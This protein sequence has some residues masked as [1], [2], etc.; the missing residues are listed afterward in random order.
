MY[1]AN[2]YC[3]LTTRHDVLESYM[4]WLNPPARRSYPVRG[5]FV[6]AL[7]EKRGWTQEEFA[8]IVGYSTRLIRKA[9]ASEGLNPETIGDIADALGTPSAP[10]YPE[11][12]V[13]DPLAA[14]KLFIESYDRYERSMLDHCGHLFAEDAVFWCAGE[15]SGIPFAGTYIGV[16]GFQAFLDRFFAII[17]R[18]KVKPFVPIYA[19]AGN[20]VI[21]KY[22]ETTFIDGE[23]GPP[24]WIVNI[25]RYQRGKIVSIEN[26]FDT[27]LGHKALE[28]HRLAQ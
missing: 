28:E 10:I 27:H 4:S 24:L 17:R 20:E 9:E 15:D 2:L 7:R 18:D 6:K 3:D 5:E 23:I 22:E 11:D 21:A 19:V 16:A 14:A 13:C 8:A 26:F 1:I 12:L 25:T